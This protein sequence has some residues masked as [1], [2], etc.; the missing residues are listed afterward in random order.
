[1]SYEYRHDSSQAAAFFE[2]AFSD[3]S[4]RDSL[5]R[6]L[7]GSIRAAHT[8]SAGSWGLTFHLG[9]AV[10]LNVGPIQT[11]VVHADGSTEIVFD[12]G[13]L[14][15][16]SQE[17]IA[18]FVRREAGTYRRIP[19]A[20]DVTASPT[21]LGSWMDRL[22]EAH[23]SLVVK[24]AAGARRTNYLAAHS[25]GVIDY[26]VTALD[27]DVPQPAYTLEGGR[28]ISS[29]I[30]VLLTSRTPEDLTVRQEAEQAAR[31]LL[32]QRAGRMTREEAFDLGRLLN[33]TAKQGVRRYDRFSPAFH[34]ASMETLTED[35]DNFNHWTLRM[36]RG[37]DDERLEAVDEVLRD[38]SALRGAGSSYPTVL[39]Y[40]KDP[41]HYAVWLS[42]TDRGVKLATEEEWPGRSGGAAA[43]QQYNAAAQRFAEELELAPQDLDFV[44]SGLGR[45]ERTKADA[46][47]QPG[48]AVLSRGLFTF[49]AD[50]RDNNTRAWMSQ[51][52]A[53]YR[54]LLF[55]PFRAFMEALASGYIRDLDPEINTSVKTGQVM[56]SIR[57]RWPD[58]EGEYHPYYWGAFS[59][60][61][62]QEDVQLF[63][64]TP[65]DALRF[66][67][68]VSDLPAGR[69]EAWVS[70]IQAHASEIW[71][72]LRPRAAELRFEFQDDRATRS[73][74]GPEDLRKWAQEKHPAIVAE[75]LPDDPVTTSP[76][77]LPIVGE[78]LSYLHPI[79]ALA[80]GAPFSS[81]LIT[82]ERPPEE[83]LTEGEAKTLEEVARETYLPIEQLE[84]W[85]GLLDGPKP[86]ALFY[87]PPG[88]GKTF[89]ARG[90]AEHLAGAS[91]EVLCVQFHPSFSYEDFIEGLRPVVADGQIRYEVRRGLFTSFCE[92]ARSKRGRYVMLID[93]IN[94]AELGAVLGELMMLLEYREDRVQL[95]YSQERFGIPRNVVILATMNTADR[96]L[97]LVDFALRRRF[98]A[99]EMRP[100]RDVLSAY[101]AKVD[102]PPD[103]V[104]K[105]FDI[106]QQRV[107]SPDYAP[108]HSY[109]MKSDLSPAGLDRLW[110]F[111]LRPYLAEYWF[112][113]PSRLADLSREVAAL[114]A[115]G[116]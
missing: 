104:L 47:T 42:I 84:E 51:N 71:E 1:M 115:E 53:R 22:Q 44:L 2:K 28:D 33:T 60:H 78:L 58:Q 111:E 25:P 54:E 87:G 92:R 26:L 88:T 114:L 43:Y 83:E 103:L 11:L 94:R 93:E 35:M 3:R 80:W 21:D 105:F 15:A 17:E 5:L 67:L 27:T 112:E 100:D 64:N 74:D 69:H 16:G 7:V 56:A 6:F 101:L 90:L 86:Q 13:G 102:E 39:L 107:G 31:T 19:E 37:T 81:A 108:G 66:G 24:A 85:V 72:Y 77:A 9:S 48:P 23:R 10:R 70:G 59:R 96:S 20:A 62:K 29:A 8:E 95:P 113:H 38:P 18:S 68:Y 12:W 30:T 61:R 65:W 49:L 63:V 55:N 46:R 52:E 14:D 57:K 109:W 34:G 75:L 82:E 4:A 98:H 73:V 97:A 116:T 99:I 36:W 45:L 40:L 91:G 50:L 89:V 110:R 76:E 32:D 106:V 41:D 79:A